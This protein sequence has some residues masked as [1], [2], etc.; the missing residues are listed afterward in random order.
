MSLRIFQDSVHLVDYTNIT[1]SDAWITSKDLRKCSEACE[2]WACGS[3]V[4]GQLD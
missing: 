4:G 1:Y 3:C 2:M